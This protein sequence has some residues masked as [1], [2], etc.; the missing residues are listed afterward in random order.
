MRPI[1]TDLIVLAAIITAGCDSPFF[2]LDATV[3]DCA[4]QAPLADVTAVLHFDNEEEVRWHTNEDG[5]LH[6]EAN[7]L[8]SAAAILTL[9]KH[10]Y[11]DGWYPYT[12]DP[13]R[14]IDIC[15]EPIVP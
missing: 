12:G 3:T 15:L 5:K 7:S 13:D 2:T 4:T 1:A 14:Q 11:Q 6:I 8:E 9:T 10:G